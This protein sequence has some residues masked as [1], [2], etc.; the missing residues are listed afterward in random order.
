MFLNSLQIYGIGDYYQLFRKK[1]EF[2]DG[3]REKLKNEKI[4]VD[5]LAEC[6]RIGM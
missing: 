6:D 1:S 3:S 5:L 2:I 4:I